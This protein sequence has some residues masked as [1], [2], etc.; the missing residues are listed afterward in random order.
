MHLRRF[1]KLHYRGQAYELTVPMPEGPISAATAARLGEAF[2]DE[3]ERT[4]GHRAGPEEPVELA[5]LN[6][7]A[8]GQLETR[9]GTKQQE[10]PVP[11]EPPTERRAYF[12]GTHGWM[13]TPVLLRGHLAQ[14]SWVGPVIIEEYD[15]TCVVP[16]GMR[17][18]LD[19]YGNIVIDTSAVT[20]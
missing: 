3:H 14:R 19:P 20:H 9:R 8:G 6:L 4:Y 18:A 7:S 2:G 1:A 17:V 15:C 11:R 5:S 10:T 16:P 13:T 12:G